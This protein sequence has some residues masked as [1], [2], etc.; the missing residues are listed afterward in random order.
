MYY[1]MCP[2]PSSPQSPEEINKLAVAPDGSDMD[3]AL[4]ILKGG[5]PIQQLSVYS[6][7]HM[8]IDTEDADGAFKKLLPYI[9][10]LD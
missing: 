10:V 6:N 4:L 9:K 2:A 3:R 8:Y 5:Q 7:I 1:C